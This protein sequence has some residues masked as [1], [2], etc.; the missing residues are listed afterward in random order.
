V[1]H[2]LDIIYRLG[3]SAYFLIAWDIIRYSMSRGFH[4]VGRGSGANSVVAYCLKITDVDPIDLN[5]YFER[6]INPKR[7][8]PPDFDI[9][10][11]WDQREEVQDYIFKR[12]GREHTALLGAMSTFKG[13]S[14]LRELG[15]VY[16]LPKQEIDD[17]VESPFSRYNRNSITQQIYG[18]ARMMVD[19]PNIR[20][21]H[22][23][24][25][26]ISEK[27]IT[28]YTALDMPPKGFLTTQWDMY[29][30]EISAS[31]SWISSASAASDTLKNAPTLSVKIAPLRSM[32]TRWIS[33]SKTRRCARN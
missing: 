28:C 5:L 3:F 19:F 12:Y 22:A 31:R 23:G 24:G 2:E 8:S 14:I 16:G 33:S 11:S 25:V 29:V 27:P 4:H 30:A 32:C 6:F 7:S 9:D 17:L 10:Y 13:K 18:I 15:K 21:I 1:R 20:S 26:L